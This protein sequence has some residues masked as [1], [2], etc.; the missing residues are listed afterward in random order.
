MIEASLWHPV[1]QASD[2]QQAPVGVRL[3]E[4]DLVV[5]RDAQGG[6]HAFADQC[7]HR[8]ARLSLGRVH[9]GRLECPYHGWRFEGSGRCVAV[10]AVPDFVPPVGH[11]A[12]AH[13][14]AESAGLVW[15]RLA[16]GADAPVAVDGEDDPRLRK[17]T[18]GP[19]D[20]AA[21]APR[22]VENFLD[23]SHFGFVHEGWLGDRAHTAQA[24]YQVQA[25]AE[26]LL[27]TGCR[28]WQPQSNRL[29]TEGSE[30]AYTYAVNAPYTAALT[31]LPQAQDGYR[32]V[33]HLFVCPLEPELSRVWFRMAVTDFASTDEELR[34]F[35]HTI[36]TQDRPVLESQRPKR[37]PLSGGEL[38]SAADRLSTAYRRYL[39]EQ[40]ITF[41][42]LA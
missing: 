21:S 29:S 14:A 41:G 8:G 4:Q 7:P 3:L 35:Q 19:Y 32:D 17:L 37:L 39:R 11:T 5:W 1:C 12:R 23:L 26:G 36:F 42:V 2:V 18:V 28:A 34:A 27:A 33:I 20:V 25:T 38:H 22:V 10:P 13:A 9:E 30:V 40:G 31:K 24:G 15:V 6:L 16:P